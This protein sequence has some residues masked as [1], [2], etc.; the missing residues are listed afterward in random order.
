MDYTQESYRVRCEW[1]EGGVKILAPMCDVIVIVDV[2][3]FSTCVDVALSREAEVYPYAW[4]D[5][6]GRMYAEEIGGVLAEKRGTSHFSLSPF[7]L[8]TLPAKTKL[9]LPSPNGSTL[10]TIAAEQVD[11]VI[12][13]CLR[14]AEAVGQMLSTHSGTIGVIPAGERWPDGSLRPALEDWLGAG[15][16]LAALSGDLSPEAEVAANLFESTRSN[17]EETLLNCS[18]GRELVDRGFREDVQIA[19]ELNVSRNVP[20]LREGRYVRVEG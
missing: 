1:G 20:T 17:L 13:S 14:N 10:T 15:A 3:S 16:V 8:Q 2:L 9:V 4:K 11:L 7:S 12:T 19:A 18:S 6:R 5:E